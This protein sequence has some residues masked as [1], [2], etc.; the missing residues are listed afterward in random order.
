MPLLV[1]YQGKL[2][3]IAKSAFIAENATLIGD[4]EIGEEASVWFG[5]VLRGDVGPIRVGDR[6]NIQDLSCIHATFGLS[7][8]TVGKDV[9]VGHGVILHGCTIEDEVLVGMGSIVLDNAVV[10]RRSVIA[11]GALVTPR[12]VVPP[13]QM[14]MGRPGKIVRAVT[15]AEAAMGIDGARHYVENARRYRGG[16]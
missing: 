3:R 15:E 7:A 1:P 6:S 8:T 13:G 14:V 5:C 4:V 16:D 11:A 10:G 12:T 9:T 2:P